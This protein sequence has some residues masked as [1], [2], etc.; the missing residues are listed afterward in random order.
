MKPNR[1]YYRKDG[2]TLIGTTNNGGVFPLNTAG[3]TL[4]NSIS[5]V[6]EWYWTGLFG[7]GS[8]WTTTI[9][10]VNWTSSQHVFDATGTAREGHGTGTTGN[11]NGDNGAL[12]GWLQ[13]CDDLLHLVCVEQ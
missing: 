4:S 9:N 1:N 5:G 3:Q 6:D 2:V 7:E 10:C 11:T 13:W 12:A 8:A